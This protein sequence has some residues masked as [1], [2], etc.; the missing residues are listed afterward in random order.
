MK[1]KKQHEHYGGKIRPLVEYVAKAVAKDPRLATDT[2]LL[3]ATLEAA[4]PGYRDK[5]RCYN[6]DGSMEIALYTAGVMEGLLI[7]AMAREVRAAMK[8]LEGAPG[9]A[10][11]EVFTRANL[12]HVPTLAVSDATRH[13]VTRA[14]YLGLV[15]QPDKRRGS[16]YWLITHWGWKLLRGEP[17]PR[18]VKYW[19]GR[20]VARSSL[21]TT[22][23]AM[24][25]THTD[26]VQRAVE[27]RKAIR[28][29]YRADIARWDARE[30]V[31]FGGFVEDTPLPQ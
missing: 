20:L 8:R 6:C 9:M 23:S 15:H 30:W 1:K 10:A 2:A 14:A 27:R 7:L 13:A 11:G 28:A 17:V 29:D 24:F 4:V 18:A 12:V 19:R 26:L 5:G 22:L 21:T 3:H 31:G 25:K 16:G